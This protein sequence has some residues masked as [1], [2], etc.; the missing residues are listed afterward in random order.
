MIIKV[1]FL[2]ASV[3]FSKLSTTSNQKYGCAVLASVNN[4]SICLPIFSESNC[5]GSLQNIKDDD[6]LWHDVVIIEFRSANGCGTCLRPRRVERC[7]RDCGLAAKSDHNGGGVKTTSVSFGEV[8]LK[9][10]WQAL[11]TSWP[12]SIE[13][14]KE[15]LSEAHAS[16]YEGSNQSRFE[17]VRQGCC[18]RCSWW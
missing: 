7:Y 8:T 16:W 14:L 12:L 5:R 18:N 17:T 6:G 2:V 9:T 4:N 15:I 1:S 3:H 10:H 13:D 11:K